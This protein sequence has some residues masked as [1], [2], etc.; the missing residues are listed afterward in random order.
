MFPVYTWQEAH[1]KGGLPKWAT[2]VGYPGG[3]PKW[4][5]IYPGC[6]FMGRATVAAKDLRPP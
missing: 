6:S 4:A 5:T 2:Q 3:L 1:L